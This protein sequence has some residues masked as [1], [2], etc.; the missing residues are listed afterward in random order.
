MPI[1]STHDLNKVLSFPFLWAQLD[2]KH[3]FPPIVHP[4]GDNFTTWI[5]NQ[6]HNN[7][8]DRAQLCTEKKQLSPKQI[9]FALKIARERNKMIIWSEEICIASYV[10]IWYLAVL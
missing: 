6:W 9:Y 1:L 8:L 5:S 2:L 4:F 7:S 3:A 10:S